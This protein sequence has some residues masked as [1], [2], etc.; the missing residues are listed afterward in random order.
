LRIRS[1]GRSIVGE[2]GEPLQ[3]KI[4]EAMSRKNHGAP[5]TEREREVFVLQPRTKC[6]ASCWK[7]D[8]D[9]TMAE[10]ARCKLTAAHAGSHL[11]SNGNHFVG[12]G[13][14]AEICTV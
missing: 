4:G 11:D 1:V 3:S 9:N 14:S 5:L 2:E 12:S 10:A 6:D 13:Q 7:G 8:P